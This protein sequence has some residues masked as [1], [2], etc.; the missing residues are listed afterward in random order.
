[1]AQ[2][3][4][5][6]TVGFKSHDGSSQI[7]G[8][9]WTPE[10]AGG[11]GRSAVRPAGI[12]QLVHGMSEYVGR[13]DEFARVLAGCGYVVCGSDHI[14]HGKSVAS[15]A[16]L[17]HLPSHGGMD[18]LV[19]DVHELRKIVSSR[20]SSQTPYFVF[21]HSMGSFVS[22]VYIARH[23][24]GLAGA[25]LCGTGNQPVSLSKAGN[26]L[27]RILCAVRGERSYSKLLNGMA[28]GAY[29]K[30]IAD[31]RTPLDWLST[32]PAVVDA[33]IADELSGAPFTVGGY[34]TLTELTGASASFAF[35]SRVPKE[36]PLLFIAGAEDP[37][38]DNGVGVR[39]AAALMSQAGMP[40]V[41]T[42]LYEGM[43]H[44]ILNEPGRAQVHADVLAWLGK[45]AEKKGA[46]HAG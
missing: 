1:M 13:Y 16:D 45:H 27:A 31:A 30:C 8:L 44:E 28:D 14:G 15:P 3:V 38:G 33:Y 19:E 5:R 35:A 43:R 25:V 41:G 10:G 20:Y 18:I 6:T 42:I 36:L 4:V 40:N 21:G 7:K 26:L 9:M 24:E 23:G 17:G 11:G 12:V 39:A 46:P 32:D 37:V 22:R 29:S 34:A 2:S